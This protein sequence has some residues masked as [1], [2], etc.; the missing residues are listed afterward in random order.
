[1]KDLKSLYQE[2]G[3]SGDDRRFLPSIWWEDGV[4]YASGIGQTSQ[5]QGKS[6]KCVQ[7]KWIRQP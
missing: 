5:Y 3:I 2:A 1:S 6:G 4:I 7:L